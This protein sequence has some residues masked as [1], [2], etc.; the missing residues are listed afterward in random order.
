[1]KTIFIFSK[2]AA[3]ALACLV[4]ITSGCAKSNDPQAA[5]AAKETQA[6]QAAVTYPRSPVSEA[7]ADM[8][9]GGSYDLSLAAAGAAGTSEDDLRAYPVLLLRPRVMQYRRIATKPSALRPLSL[10]RSPI[11]GQLFVRPPSP[12]DA[13]RLPSL[14]LPEH[15]RRLSERLFRTNTRLRNSLN[16]NWQDNY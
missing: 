16:I 9:R 7:C 5:Q 11:A 13:E 12:F 8:T 10:R 2:N 6:A 4:L 15:E 14:Q 3:T 1:M